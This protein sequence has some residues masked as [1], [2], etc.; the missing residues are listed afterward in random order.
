VAV[1]REPPAIA[2]GPDAASA[3]TAGCPYSLTGVSADVF[4]ESAV[5]WVALFVRSPDGVEESIA[6][7]PEG[8][9]WRATMGE[10]VTAGQAVFW[11]EATDS[12]GNRSRAADQV[13]DV[14]SCD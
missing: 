12:E 5:T 7:S 9:R 14:F 1:D 3:Y 10:F 2:F 13:L 8:E 6:M 4:D 11:V